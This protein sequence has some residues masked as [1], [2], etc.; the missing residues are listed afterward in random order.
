MGYRQLKEGLEILV[1][2]KVW[3]LKG[4]GKKGWGGRVGKVG[5][6]RG[7][8]GG[9]R[10]GTKQEEEGSSDIHEDFGVI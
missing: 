10:E 7:E 3:V 5:F 8:W 9:C 6:K 1:F 4:E 2:D